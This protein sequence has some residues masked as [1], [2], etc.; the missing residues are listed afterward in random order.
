MSKLL[1]WR[2]KHMN[3]SSSSCKVYSFWLKLDEITQ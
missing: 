2:K 1:L 3:S